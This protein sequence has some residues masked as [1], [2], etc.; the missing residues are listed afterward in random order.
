[1]LDVRLYRGRMVFAPRQCLCPRRI[2]RMYMHS[3]FVSWTFRGSDTLTREIAGDESA[4]QGNA[5]E[6]TAARTG[7]GVAKVCQIWAN[8]LPMAAQSQGRLAKEDNAT[9]EKVL[10]HCLKP[11]LRGR[12]S[13]CCSRGRGGEAAPRPMLRAKLW[14]RQ[15]LPVLEL[16]GRR[17]S[18]KA[19]ARCAALLPK[20]VPRLPAWRR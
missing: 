1:M 5:A 12:S 16:G 2:R 13:S 9:K 8:C 7:C 4:T 11:A 20:L 15:C 6:V 3:L 18:S 17:R 19:E 10:R 14:Q